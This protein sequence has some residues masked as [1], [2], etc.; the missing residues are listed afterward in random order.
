MSL[1]MINKKLK[2]G[3]YGSLDELVKDF[4]LVSEVLIMFGVMIYEKSLK[5]LKYFW[6]P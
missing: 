1:F 3:K 2:M 6:F 5:S 4:A